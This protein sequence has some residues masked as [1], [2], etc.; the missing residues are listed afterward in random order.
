MVNFGTIDGRDVTFTTE[1]DYEIGSPTPPKP[2]RPTGFYYDERT[3]KLYVDEDDAED[4]DGGKFVLERAD[5]HTGEFEIVNNN[6][7]NLGENGVIEFEDIGAVV[8]QWWRLKAVSKN[9]ISSD[10]TL[11]IWYPDPSWFIK[12]IGRFQDGNGDAIKG[13]KVEA[14]IDPGL[15]QEEVIYWQN[16]IVLTEIKEESVSDEEGIVELKLLRS[17][18]IGNKEYNFTVTHSNFGKSFKCELP[19][20]IEKNLKDLMSDND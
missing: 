10:Y 6:I 4:M 8:G 9:G 16:S 14:K 11:P 2:N 3:K 13:V 7:S 18:K 1:E 17:S 20:E 12:I 15:G 19:D 5:S